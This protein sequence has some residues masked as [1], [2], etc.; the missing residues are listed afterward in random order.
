[1]HCLHRLSPQMHCLHRFP[2]A[3]PLPGE[4]P[5][6]VSHSQSVLNMV[7]CIMGVG[8]LGYPYCFKSSGTVLAT[9]VMLVTMVATR[10]SYQLLL[11]AAQ[12]S[13]KKTFEQVQ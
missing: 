1:M 8:V 10:V 13:G 5:S 11:H 9:L 3:S 2:Q 4:G 6:K 12:A 7:N